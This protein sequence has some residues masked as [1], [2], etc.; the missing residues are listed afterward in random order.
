MFKVNYAYFDNKGNQKQKILSR[1][2][3]GGLVKAF[4]KDLET[5]EL[6]HIIGVTP[7]LKKYDFKKHGI[8]DFWEKQRI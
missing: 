6:Y 5:K 7:N 1:K 4:L 8:V 3:L 2:T